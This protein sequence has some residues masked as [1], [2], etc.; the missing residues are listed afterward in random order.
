MKK[1]KLLEILHSSDTPGIDL[2][3]HVKKIF[4]RKISFYYFINLFYF[5]LNALV[6]VGNIIILR[7]IRIEDIQNIFDSPAT[8]YI[9]FLVIIISLSLSSF[10][11]GIL[12]FFKTKEK[13]KKLIKDRN[14]ILDSINNM[15]SSSEEEWLKIVEKMWEN[16]IIDFDSD[17]EQI[18]GE[19]I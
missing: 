15:T 17:S 9:L 19:N 12:G 2:Y 7:V 4:N 6:V 8:F 18:K 13:I 10:I 11:N 3:K 16:E 1:A 14:S 5:T